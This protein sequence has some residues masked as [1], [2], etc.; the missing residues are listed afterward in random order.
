[1][2]HLMNRRSLLKAAAGLGTLASSGLAPLTARAS[3]PLVRIDAHAHLIPDFYRQS[4]DAHGVLDASGQALPDWSPSAALS[5]MNRFGIQCQVL[6]LPEPGLAFLPDLPSRVSMATQLND[7]LRD[8]LVF[9]SPGHPNR[10]LRWLCHF[11]LG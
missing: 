11:A 8:E 5:F 9:A 2:T 1:M 7:Y 3:T 10:A 4:L 6:S